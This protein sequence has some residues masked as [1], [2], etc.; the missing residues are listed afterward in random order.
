MS[1]VPRSEDHPQP[2]EG[3]SGVC[4]ICGRPE[5]TGIAEVRSEKY[6]ERTYNFFIHAACLK[7]VAKPGF[8]G[9]ADI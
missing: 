4:V 7:K 2:N 1:E 8:V 3:R 9:I 6:P 5:A